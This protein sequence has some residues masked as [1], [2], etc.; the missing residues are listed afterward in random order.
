MV[1]SRKLQD[2]KFITC[3]SEFIAQF[4][5]YIKII[6]SVYIKKSE[7]GIKRCAL[8]F[9]LCYLWRKQASILYFYDLQFFPTAYTQNLFMPH[10]FWNLSLKV[11]NYTPNLQT[12]KLFLSLW[13]NFNTCVMRTGCST[14]L[15]F[16]LINILHRLFRGWTQ[17]RSHTHTPHMCKH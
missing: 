17:P 5:V 16:R 7:C 12:H 10:D 15:R 13:L 6:L 2:S 3:N 11:Q 8:P 4:S 9:Y 1:N 14:H